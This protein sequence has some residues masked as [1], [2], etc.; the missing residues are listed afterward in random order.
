MVSLSDG[1]NTVMIVPT[2]PI[3]KAKTQ[4]YV[5]RFIP[6][7]SKLY[8]K[9]LGSEGLRIQVEG[10]LLGSGYLTD[11]ERLQGW[12]D[13]GASLTYTDEAE[14]TGVSVRLV[15]FSYELIP[16]LSQILRVALTL[17]EA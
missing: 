12:H 3:V 8:T 4:R 9:P 5:E 6:G 15:G 14:T 11:K 1:T 10:L 17:L 13:T 7:G 16:G 2:K